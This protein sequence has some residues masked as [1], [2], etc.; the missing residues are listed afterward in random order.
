M[1][2]QKKERALSALRK[3]A[4]RY[5]ELTLEIKALERERGKVKDF[6]K[7]VLRRVGLEAF[8]FVV[9]IRKENLR[10][11]RYEIVTTVWNVS[12]LAQL[13]VSKWKKVKSEQDRQALRQCLKTVADEDAV[14][15]ALERGLLTLEEVGKVAEVR[16]SYGFRVDPYEE[17]KS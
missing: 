17:E 4:T 11:L 6:C 2:T 5:H 13:I 15:A 12:G 10:A 16:K 1:E 8:R 3:Q 7:E 9:D 14:K